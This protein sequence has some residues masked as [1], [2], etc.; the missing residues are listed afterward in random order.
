M[1][2]FEK[3]TMNAFSSVFPST[4]VLGCLFNLGQSLW[5]RIQSE[6]LSAIY[7]DDENIK[8]YSKMLISLSFVPIEDVGSAFDELSESRPIALCN[9]YGYWEDNYVGRLRRDRRAIP[10]FPISMWN[11][12]ERVVEGL[13]RTNNSVEGWHNVFQSSVGCHHPT[14][15]SLVEHFRREQDHIEQKISRIH[16]GLT[17]NPPSSKAKYVQLTRRLSAIIPTYST[18]ELKDYLSAISKNIDF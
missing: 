10:L 7:R 18:R 3:A 6:R 4:N 17:N 13:P 16:A 12:R 9:L 1:I 5:R 15:Y 2:D 11:M 14:I 8:L